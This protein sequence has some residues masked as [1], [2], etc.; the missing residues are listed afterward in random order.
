M[1]KV[2]NTTGLQPKIEV[3][4][5]KSIVWLDGEFHPVAPAGAY[6]VDAVISAQGGWI[7]GPEIAK[8]AKHGMMVGSRPDRVRARLPKPIRDLI[9]SSGGRGFRLRV[10]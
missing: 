2:A 5:E 8:S 10:A 3:N 9:E 4:L 7:S 1:A 6:F